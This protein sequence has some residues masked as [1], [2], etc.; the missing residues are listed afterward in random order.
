MT[1]RSLLML[2]VLVFLAFVSDPALRSAD[3]SRPKPSTFAP[4]KDLLRQWESMLKRCGEDLAD[5]A[6]YGD[7]QQ[8]RV[9]KDAN[10]LVVIAQ[11]LALHDEDHAAKK[12]AAAWI[13][14]A[15]KLAESAEEFATA[16]VAYQELKAAKEVDQEVSPEPI[17]EISSLM[18]QVPIINN[19]LRRGV[20][21]TRFAKSLDVS[22]AQ[23]ATLAAIAERSSF[24]H[25]YCESPDDIQ[26]WEKVCGEM[27]DAAAETLAAVR[28]SEQTAASAGLDRLVKSCDACHD[29]FRKQ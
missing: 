20:T 1:V 12:S 25:S 10:T 16:H 9:V 29:R 2:A 3:P 28:K 4:A 5:E 23:A 6:E 7:D 26:L 19:A 11:M 24:D 8:G 15:K 21:G 17:A 14:A 13:A 22:A 18:K 27:R